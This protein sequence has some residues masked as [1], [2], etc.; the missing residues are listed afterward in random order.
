MA[1]LAKPMYFKLDVKK[2]LNTPIFMGNVEKLIPKE[3][4]VSFHQNKRNNSPVI[5]IEYVA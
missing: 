3:I 4:K 1:E 5:C 2:N